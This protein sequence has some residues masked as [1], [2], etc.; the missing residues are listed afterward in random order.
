MSDGISDGYDYNNYGS[1]A[2]WEDD[3]IVRC[4]DKIIPADLALSYNYACSMAG[5]LNVSSAVICHLIERIGT[6]EKENMRLKQ[7]QQ[8]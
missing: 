8:M 4:G 7:K 6:L 3:K 5:T 2:Y 1:R